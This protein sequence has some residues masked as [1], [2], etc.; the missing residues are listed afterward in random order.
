MHQN[1]LEY[2]RNLKNKPAGPPAA[3]KRTAIPQ[4]SAK[5]IE[6]EKQ[7]KLAGI[8]P[9]PRSVPAKKSDK[10]KAEERAEIAPNGKTKTSNFFREMIEAAP[11]LCMETDQPLANTAYNESPAA[12]VCHI[13]PKRKASQGGVP[14]MAKN[15]LNIVYLDGE[16]HDLM[17]ADMG[18][19]S[20]GNYIRAMRIYPLLRERV[21][22]MWPL[23]PEN[24][25]VN[26]P[27]FL[28]PDD[29]RALAAP[30]GDYIEFEEIN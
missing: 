20:Q 15:P 6:Q 2:R 18:T 26:V 14:S 22:L 19:K 9:P 10:K 5:R 17:D 24:E 12:V 4:K 23:I 8:K 7:D 13:L 27:W 28:R 25:R 16:V 1:Y 3:P 30:A 21:A 11:V 29:T